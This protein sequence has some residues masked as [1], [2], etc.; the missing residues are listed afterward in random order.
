MTQSEIEQ[1]ISEDKDNDADDKKEDTG[2]KTGISREEFFF[3][4][5][6][7]LAD[8]EIE[9]EKFEAIRDLLSMCNE[10]GLITRFFLDEEGNPSFES[11]AKRSLGSPFRLNKPLVVKP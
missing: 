2:E 5:S 7:M 4:L 8:G 6:G 10:V 1:P 11:E 9:I 3:V